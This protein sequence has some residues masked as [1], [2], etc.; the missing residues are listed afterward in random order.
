MAGGQPA[1]RLNAAAHTVT[2]ATSGAITGSAVIRY[3]SASRPP[4]GTCYVG[5]RAYTA[6]GVQYTGSA[7]ATRPFQ[8]HTILTGTLSMR[9]GGNGSY[10][11]VTLTP[12]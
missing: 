2:V 7:R 11:A 8:A 9:P 4:A 12:R 1:P 3:R 10:A 5:G 6:T